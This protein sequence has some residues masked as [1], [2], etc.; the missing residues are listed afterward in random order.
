MPLLYRL[1]FFP[2]F[3]PMAFLEVLALD[4][5]LVFLVA[6]LRFFAFGPAAF[7]FFTTPLPAATRA[8]LRGVLATRAFGLALAATLLFLGLGV[9]GAGAAVGGACFSG[10]GTSIGSSA[11]PSSPKD[12]SALPVSG[13]VGSGFSAGFSMSS[14]FTLYPP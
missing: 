2:A 12:A 1:L 3:L 14:I 13:S 10:G 11:G 8:A 7:A 4:A 9:A 5:I 6:D